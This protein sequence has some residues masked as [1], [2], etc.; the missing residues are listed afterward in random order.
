MQGWIDAATL[1]RTLN[2]QG[3]FLAYPAEGLPFLLEEGTE[4][5]LVPPATDAPRHVTV[6][7]IAPMA[8]KREGGYNVMFAEVADATTAELLVGCHC[9]VR[10]DEVEGGLEAAAALEEEPW[11]V[12]DETFGPLGTLVRI[13]E[14]PG[15]SLLVVERPAEDDEAA[16]DLLIPLVDEFMRG[17]DE[18]AHV[19]KVAVP[20]G[21]LEL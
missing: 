21:L 10:A 1:T 8:G 16:K 12:V 18:E 13:E 17:T 4:C 5:A 2:L 3:G 6:A 7:S 14:R 15:Q 9:L 20:Q 19:I 11:D